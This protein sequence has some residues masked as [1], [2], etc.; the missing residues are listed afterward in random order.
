MSWTRLVGGDLTRFFKERLRA[1][2][3][4]GATTTQAEFTPRRYGR[5]EQLGVE[6]VDFRSP[7]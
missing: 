1:R 7:L 3:I 4:L 6:P 5:A 2:L